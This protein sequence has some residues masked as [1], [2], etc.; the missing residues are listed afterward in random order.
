MRGL[1]TIIHQF[2][3]CRNEQHRKLHRV[4]IYIVT[5]VLLWPIGSL[6]SC[7]YLDHNVSYNIIY[8][9]SPAL[10]HELQH[11]FLHKE[12]FRILR[13]TSTDG[14]NTDRGHWLK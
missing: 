1:D 14:V 11:Y 3:F 13:T 5:L 12:I 6:K 10:K 9:I 8:S 2:A 7:V 4:I